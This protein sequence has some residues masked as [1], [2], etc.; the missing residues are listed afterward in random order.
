MDQQARHL[1]KIGFSVKTGARALPIAGAKAKRRLQ[2][3]AD[4]ANAQGP[5]DDAISRLEPEIFM[6]DPGNTGCLCLCRHAAGLIEFSTERFLTDDRPR[7]V[8]QHRFNRPGMAC[9]GDD[10]I[11]GIG[12]RGV[13]H[14]L[15]FKFQVQRLI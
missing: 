12:A 15:G 3:D 7:P 2:R 13:Q 6:H 14:L 1:L 8:G 10:D 5:G 4:L 9:R 11:D